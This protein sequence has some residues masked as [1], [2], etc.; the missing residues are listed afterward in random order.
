[1]RITISRKS[2]AIRPQPVA[3]AVVAREIGRRL[4][5]GDQVVAGEA[6]LDGERQRALPDLGAELARLLDRRLDRRLHARLDPLDLVQLARDADPQ[7]LQALA[8]RQLD[9][10]H[11]DGG[12]VVLV[13]AA[14]IR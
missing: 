7:S 14:M 8:L 10:R 5:R 11:L 4:G 1:M 13:P 6:V 2:S 9:R 3:N 12:R